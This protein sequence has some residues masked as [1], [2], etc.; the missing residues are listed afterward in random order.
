MMKSK[1]S[2]TQVSECPYQNIN[3][4]S[5][6][7]LEILSEYYEF[8]SYPSVMSFL[9]PN[10]N[11][12]FDSK[13]LFQETRDSFSIGIQFSNQIFSDMSSIQSKSNNNKKISLNTASVIAE[14]IS[15][16]QFIVNAV[17]NQK[18][19]SLIDIEMFG[20]ID[21]F[22]CLMH[23]NF[24]HQ[25]VKIPNRWQNLHDI[26]DAIFSGPRFFNDNNELYIEAEKRAFYHLKTAFQNIWD[27]TFCDFS[28]INR[29]SKEYLKK[30][31]RIF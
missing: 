15:H 23:W 13:V 12:T 9:M 5:E 22:L 25:T 11:E 7:V 14:E 4:L 16:F 3:E 30:L 26:C 19:I 17:E 6:T 8:E 27:N 28:R 29:S 20:E 2:L 1:Q 18:K 10:S 31:R 21:R 24:K